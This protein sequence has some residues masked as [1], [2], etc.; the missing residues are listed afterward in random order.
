MFCPSFSFV[1]VLVC[2]GFV[3]VVVFSLSPHLL[4]VL[5]SGN[6][7]SGFAL[8]LNLPILLGRTGVSVCVNAQFLAGVK[9]P[10]PCLET[11]MD[12]WSF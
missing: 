11:N 2:L 8:L 4:N 6:E 3:V 10:K 5:I 12:L 9:P 7:I 1:L